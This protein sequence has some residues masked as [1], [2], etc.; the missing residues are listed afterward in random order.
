MLCVSSLW[1]FQSKAF[2]SIK[3]SSLSEKL[4]KAPLNPYIINWLIDF[5]SDRKQRVV[6][7]NVVTEWKCVNRGTTQR[8]VNGPY[9]DDSAVL[10]PVCRGMREESEKLL[11]SFLHWIE[12][13]NMKCNTD[14]C[15]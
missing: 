14:K 13:N 8:N 5:L 4:K 1:I 2:D 10:I 15:Q 7:N 3:Q 9:P 11:D 6:R 12:I